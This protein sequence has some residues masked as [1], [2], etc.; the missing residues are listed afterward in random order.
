MIDSLF[1]LAYKVAYRL[2][3]VYWAVARP[4]THGA[5]VAV[6]H[7]DEILL[8]KSSY[9]NYWSLPGGY[10]Q[11]GETAVQAAL[12]ELEE[13]TG[14]SMEASALQ[15][16][17][18]LTHDWEGK[19]DHVEIFEVN[20]PEPPRVQVDRREVIDAS[21]FPPERALALPLFPPIREHIDRH[22]AAVRGK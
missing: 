7:K 15:R 20:L 9:L 2:M 18:D 16:S 1:Q 11:S 6:W 5:L 17:L 22:L 3:R 4:N 14:M 13:E 21:L 12:R 8:V 19:R 10:V